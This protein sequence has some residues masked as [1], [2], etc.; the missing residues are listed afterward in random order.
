MT[1]LLAEVATTEDALCAVVVFVVAVVAVK[2]HR[3]FREI[4]YKCTI[5]M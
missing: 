2:K 5:I 4:N 1:L 3:F